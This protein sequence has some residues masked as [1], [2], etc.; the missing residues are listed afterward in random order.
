MDAAF[1]K[2][3]KSQN[4]KLDYGEFCDLMNNRDKEKEKE[5][6][7]ELERKRAERA[8]EEKGK[9]EVDTDPLLIRMKNN[10]E[11]ANKNGD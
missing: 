7:I 11:K 8:E 6:K 4:N 5:R 2:F 1:K 3:D 9:K 10:R